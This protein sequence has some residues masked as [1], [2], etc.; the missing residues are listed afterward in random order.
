[1]RGKK[2]KPTNL[3]LVTGNPGN[4]PLDAN[5]PRPAHSIPTCPA[6]LSLS[7]KA[8]WKRLG[9]EM[10]RLRTI[11]QLDRAAM[12]ANCA[13]YGRWGGDGAPAQGHAYADPAPFRLHPAI[14]VARQL[15]LMHKSMSD[16]GLLPVS[17]ARASK[18][19]SIG[20]K[21]WETPR[22][23]DKYLRQQRGSKPEPVDEFFGN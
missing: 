5:E 18:L 9:Q 13:A 6:H 21:P 22:A 11:S 19:P 23:C 7:A 12:A 16:L 20:P 4:R 3:K 1:M 15:E 17:R 14:A 10:H 2:P 8:E